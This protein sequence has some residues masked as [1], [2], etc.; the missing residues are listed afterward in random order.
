VHVHLHDHELGEAGVHD[1]PSRSRARR[2]RRARSRPTVTNSVRTE[3]ARRRHGSFC[4]QAAARQPQMRK[5]P[6]TS[7]SK[8]LASLAVRLAHSSPTATKSAGCTRVNV[9][10]A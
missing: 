4:N 8:G 5:G 9:G 3:L 6:S 10:G 7:P 1:H 2:S